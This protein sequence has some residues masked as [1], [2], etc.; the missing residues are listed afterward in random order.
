MVLFIGSVLILVIVVMA[1][2]SVVILDLV[3][4]D[5]DGYPK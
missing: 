5:A 1:W 2:G 4:R 3:T